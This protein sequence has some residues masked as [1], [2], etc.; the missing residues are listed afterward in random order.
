MRYLLYLYI[1]ILCVVLSACNNEDPQDK[2]PN[3]KPE[4]PYNPIPLPQSNINSTYT[5]LYWK[6]TDPDNDDLLFDLYFGKTPNPLRF[7]SN[8][9]LPTTAVSLELNSTYYWFVVV[10]DGRDSVVGPEWS[11]TAIDEN[12]IPTVATQEAESVTNNSVILQGRIS[13]DGGSK[14]LEKGFFL[15]RLKNSQATGSKIPVT[16]G[17]LT[18]STSLSNL[19]NNAVYYYRGYAMNDKGTSYGIEKTFTTWKTGEISG[20]FIDARDEKVYKFQ[21]VGSQIW[22]AENLAY[23]PRVSKARDGGSNTPFYYVYGYDGYNVEEAKS[24][25]NYKIYGVLYNWIAAMDEADE[26]EAEI[27]QGACPNGWHLPKAAE[28]LDLFNHVGGESIAGGKL[29]NEGTSY[30][31]EPNRL[32][33][34]EVDWNALP[35]G[36]RI[37]SEFREMGNQGF[38]WTATLFN[39]DAAERRIIYNNLENV[40]SFSVLKETGHSVRCVRD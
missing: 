34:N 24:T 11:F 31:N 9:D 12:I 39:I 27:I 29:K 32:A 38:W 5:N 25:D 7:K 36:E 19:I 14:I 4:I 33:T 20:S 18:Y 8:L 13:D 37:P 1:C 23:L 10:K 35:G 21:R 16:S 30:W 22:M 15:S 6:A 28:W 40:G 3:N 26:N 2:G 17:S